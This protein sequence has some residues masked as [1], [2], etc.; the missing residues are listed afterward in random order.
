MREVAIV[1]I[2]ITTFGEMW[3]KSFREIG[4][5]A[6]LMAIQ[7]AKLTAEE[8]DAMYV[9]NMSAGRYIE[10]EHVAALIADY[11]GLARD[12]TPATRIEAAGAS[13]GLALRQAYMAV[14]SGMHDI[15]IVGGA[16]KMTDVGDAASNAIQ[17]SAADQQWESVFGATS[18]SLH[19]MIARRHMHQYGTT[20]EQIA[21]VAV[22][23]HKHGA[24]NPNAQFQR[25]IDL[26]TV[27]RAGMVA[28][29]L[30][31]F[32]CAPIS[33]GAAALILCPMD[34]AKRYTDTPVKILAS[35][36]ASD[37]LAL[38]SRSDICTFEATRF[39]AM[40]AYKQAGLGPKDMD[41]CEVHDSFTI[42]EILAIEDLGFFD[43]GKGG[44]ATED[45]QTMIG[46]EIAINTSGG[47]KARGDP[48][49]A[50]GVAQIVE[51]VQ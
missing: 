5:Q 2:G 28:D 51:I 49:G 12:H 9:G 31:V 29:P 36:Q 42:S 7:D 22:K 46:G 40:R 15:V 20:R 16:E 43:K 35:A 4:I 30:G 18:P 24:L 14:A 21:Q 3:E 6:G 19:A 41:L 23:N 39:A 50:T 10:Q 45:G 48:L 26:K 1:G 34:K 8:I 38:H 44:K 47:L 17:S 11:S 32:D 33:D 27:L 37:T 13:G 25:E